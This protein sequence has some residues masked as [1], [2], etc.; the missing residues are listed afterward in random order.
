MIELDDIPFEPLHDGKYYDR[1]RF[2]KYRCKDVPRKSY[3]VIEER[4]GLSM[5]EIQEKLRF[6]ILF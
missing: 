1:S 2:G 6:N 3:S 4:F 5:R